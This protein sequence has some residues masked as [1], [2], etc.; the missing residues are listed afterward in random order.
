MKQIFFFI[1][2]LVLLA[3]CDVNKGF[4]IDGIATGVQDGKTIFL[5]ARDGENQWDTLGKSVVENERFK[6][7]GRVEQPVIAQI[8]DIAKRE[9]ITL[10][11]ENAP[12]QVEVNGEES[13]VTGGE[14]QKMNNELNDQKA[15][16]Y[17]DMPEIERV[18]SEARKAGNREKCRELIAKN[19]RLDSLYNEVERR[20]LEEY[21]NT[22]V[23][24]HLVFKHDPRMRFERLKPMYDLLSEN[25]RQTP[26]GQIIMRRYLDAKITAVG[27]IAPDFTLCT[28]EGDS[29]SL[30]SVKVKVKI[31]DFWASWCGPCR[32]ENPN[33][34]A[35]YQKYKNTGLE[36]L[37]VSLDTKREAWLKAVREDGLVWKH[38][39]DLKG[40]Q[41][42]AAQRYKINSVPSILVLDADNRIVGSFLRGK[43][44]ES[45]LESLMSE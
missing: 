1:L 24:V 30:Y 17:K 35:L 38:V 10:F 42:S 39:S 18:F 43:Q 13:R 36:I 28:P 22:L 25:M 14:L 6:F 2:P 8:Q 5:V 45:I 20:F 26:Y 41:C 40:W 12:F 19:D 33:M 3:G 27:E 31:L 7:E 16:I 9:S 11:L 21:G 37:S 29:L 23:A 15:M 44:L 34:V 32:A 4:T